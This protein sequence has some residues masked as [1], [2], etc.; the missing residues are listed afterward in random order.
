MNIHGTPEAEP[1]CPGCEVSEDKIDYLTQQLKSKEAEIER[2]KGW[3]GEVLS[4]PKHEDEVTFTKGFDTENE[5]HRIQAVYNI[6]CSFDR[7]YRGQKL[8][9]PPTPEAKHTLG[10]GKDYVSP[11]PMFDSDGNVVENRRTTPEAKRPE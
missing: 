4:C 10:S 11:I 1:V 5:E 3:V 2:L 8:L 7:I 9:S 6:S